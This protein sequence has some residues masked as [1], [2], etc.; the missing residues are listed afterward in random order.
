MTC[1]EYAVLLEK[2]LDGTLSPAEEAQMQQHEAACPACTAQR[3]ALNTLQDDLTDLTDAPEMPA[4][5][6]QAWMKRVEDDAMENRE[7]KPRSARPWT[8]M[9]ST[10]AALVFVLGGTL[11]TRD[12][13]SPRSGESTAA[14]RVSLYDTA[15]DTEG[16][17]YE[18]T[19][20]AGT[21]MLTSSGTNSA[22]GSSRSLRSASNDTTQQEQKI[23]RTASLTIGTEHYDESLSAL[24]QM[25]EDAGGWISYSSENVTG[26]GLRRAYLT[27]RLP[28]EQLDAYLSTTG[29]LGRIISRDETATNVTESYYDTQ[30]RL[31]TQL[32]LMERLQS[33]VTDTANLSDLLDL[34]SKIADTQYTI[35]SLRSSLNSTD[36]Q[37]NY[38]T[39]DITLRE[40]TSATALTDSERSLWQRLTGALKTGWEAFSDFMEDALVF[41]TAA[42]PFIGIVIIVWLIVHLLRKRRR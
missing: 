17:A 29:T 31:D 7:R 6:H 25:S 12:T 13:L 30:A 19:D 42:L 39:V 34:E 26:T 8:H 20:A 2:F 5:F 22:S 14:S 21:I 15:A 18:D 41:L 4:D 1:T 27:L 16:A 28:T 33:M 36:S 10:A 32:A 37:V 24:R 3:R 40:E 23:I 9:L 11:M 35:D 38:A